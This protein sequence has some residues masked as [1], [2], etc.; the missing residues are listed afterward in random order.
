MSKQLVVIHADGKDMFDTDA[1]SV[2]EGVLLVFTDRSLNT[3]VKAY[4]RE[5]W[6]YAEF[7]EVT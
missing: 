4:N 2:N 3:V 5:V 1:F 6:A 7:V